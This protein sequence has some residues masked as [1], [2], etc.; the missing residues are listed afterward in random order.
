VADAY[1]ECYDGLVSQLTE[2]LAALE[3][4]DADPSE[5][6]RAVV[7]VVDT[8]FGKRPLRTHIDPSQDGAEVANAVADRLRSD[9]YARIGLADLL[10]PRAV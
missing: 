5:V 1:N 10:H 3:P 6:A 8:P 7:R 9:F 2:K 4:A